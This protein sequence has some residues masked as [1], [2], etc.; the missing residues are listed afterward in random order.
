MPWEIDMLAI[1]VADATIIRYIDR[2]NREFVILIDA[3]KAGAGPIIEDHIKKWT[4]K[5][6]IDLAICTHPDDDHIGG[7]PYVL[8]HLN[9]KEFWIHDPYKHIDAVKAIRK[10]MS[11]NES[12]IQIKKWFDIL[13]EHLGHA[14]DVLTK[15]K[16][17]PSIIVREPFVGLTYPQACITVVGPTPDYYESLLAKFNDVAEILLNE[18]AS[19]IDETLT[20]K[21]LL[22]DEQY[23]NK[24]K[25]PSKP[26]ASSAIILFKPKG[27]KYLF[28]SDATVESLNRAKAECD[29]TNLYW[30][31]LPH[32]A[33]RYNINT[34]LINH[35]KPKTAY[36][37]GDGKGHYPNPA[38]VRL[39]QHAGAS[40]FMPKKSSLRHYS[41]MGERSGYIKAV[42]LN[43]LEM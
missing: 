36:V 40:V 14:K 5:K 32:H 22:S 3:G 31:D 7:F 43:G 34:E 37:S 21:N 19:R 41:G 11:L 2:K 17:H 12:T 25:D 13:L 1:G 10:E 33:S 16:S 42:P 20:S 23:V 24:A 38:V 8:D 26:N 9:I 27:K 29:L 4:T 35:F 15:L 30:M 6:S 39:L 28:T 18:S